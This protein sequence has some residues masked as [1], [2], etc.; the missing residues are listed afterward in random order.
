MSDQET[1]TPDNLPAEI[2]KKPTTL[3]GMLGTE[4]M[5]DQFARALPDHLSVE[6]FVRVAITAITKTPKL[7]Q[8]TQESFFKCLL[9]LS[10]MGLEPDGRRAHLIPYNNQKLGV[11]ECTL[12]VDYKGLVELV[13]RAGDV[14]RIHADVVCEN[15]TF[16]HSMGEITEHTYDLRHDRG[17]PYAAYAQ[18]TLNDG[19]VQAVVMS[20]DEIEAVR[21]RS[22]AGSD[23]PWV[24]DWNEMAKKSAFRRL[25]KWLTLSP[26]IHSA[27]ADA[28]ATEFAPRRVQRARVPL[29]PFKIE[30]RIAAE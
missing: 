7:A 6:R 20:R 17:K 4:Q 11:T 23:G 30:D 5:R 27:I 16:A 8:C 9:D 24:T 3:K 12:I 29:D 1:K 19:S 18:V 10:A 21:K 13:R 15:D 14:A 25:T 2:P 22:K 26:E 28:E